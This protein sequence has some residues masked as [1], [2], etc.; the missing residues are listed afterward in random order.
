MSYL[1]QYINQVGAGDEEAPLKLEGQVL[2]KETYQQV[3]TGA[4]MMYVLQG[5]ITLER[6]DAYVSP[7]DSGIS[8][9]GGLSMALAKKGGHPFVDAVRQHTRA[10]GQ[11]QMGQAIVS[12]GGHLLAKYVIH[13]YGPNA[14]V[15]LANLAP[16]LKTTISN[17]LVAASTYQIKSVSI[18]AISTGSH[19]REPSLVTGIIVK[20]V[21]EWFDANPNAS[22]KKVV[23]IGHDSQI[24]KAFQQAV[25]DAM[26]EKQGTR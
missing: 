5:D 26:R 11:L 25:D 22:V 24:S 6:L 21:C 3:N 10:K 1:F 13:A 9:A 17:S 2:R 12:I 8:L 16:I 7:S 20:A 18:P 15:P 19:G 23:F 14:S 4:Q